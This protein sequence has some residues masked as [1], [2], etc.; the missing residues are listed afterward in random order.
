MILFQLLAFFVRV[1]SL[2]VLT[3]DFLRFDHFR[4][5]LPETFLVIIQFALHLLESL[6]RLRNL[7]LLKHR[8][9]SERVR[10]IQIEYQTFNI[11]TMF[12]SIYGETR[13]MPTTYLQLHQQ[14][15]RTVTSS[16]FYIAQSEHLLHF[17]EN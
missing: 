5:Q 3:G 13:D 10:S 15:S 16:S 7:L 17:C 11:G 14:D 6:F 12:T 1:V 9:P 8:L 2:T 4:L